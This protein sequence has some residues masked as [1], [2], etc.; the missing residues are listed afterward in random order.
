[1]SGLRLV[2]DETPPGS[3]ELSQAMVAEVGQLALAALE[4]MG[5]DVLTIP[6]VD[7]DS[8]RPVSVRISRR[9]VE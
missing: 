5:T 9:S 4:L 6:V 2:T 7:P 8:G 3:E 1:M